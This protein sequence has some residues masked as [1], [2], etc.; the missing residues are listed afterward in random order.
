MTQKSQHTSDLPT[1]LLRELRY[2]HQIIRNSLSIM[3]T[4]QKIMLAEANFRDGCEGEG[5][6]RA[7]ERMNLINQASCALSENKKEYL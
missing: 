3:T 4:H 5:V 1:E 6:T 7:T 2:A